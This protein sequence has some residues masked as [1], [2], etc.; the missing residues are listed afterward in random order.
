MALSTPSEM[1]G[2]APALARSDLERL[3]AAEVR[4]LIRE[5]RWTQTTKRLALGR[6]QANLVIL[7]ERYAFDF[8][9]F[10]LRNPKPL[11]LIEVTDPGDPEP[12][13]V[14]P[15]AD[16]RTDVP[17]YRVYRDGR[18]AEEV[19]DIGDLW[20]PD[21]VAFLSGCNLSLDQVML[22]GGIPLPH[23]LSEDALASQYVSSIAC[24]PAGIFTGPMVVSMRPIPEDLLVKVIEITSRYPQCH[25][26]PVHVGDPGAI[27]IDD[28]ERVDWGAPNPV[29]PGQVPVFWACGVT[30]QAVAQAIGIPLMITHAPGHLFVT[31]LAILDPVK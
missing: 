26:A 1:T 8:M 31:D 7:E 12:R 11:P 15:G 17:A 5:G 20:R 3:D 19:S 25:G 2:E 27:G 13:R 10:C 18:M 28:L 9:R 29:G 16:L 4:R 6:E 14:A 21:H 22:D 23:L 30:A 24:E